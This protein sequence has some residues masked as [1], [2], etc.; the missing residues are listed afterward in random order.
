MDY[1]NWISVVAAVIALVS[2][3]TTI[4]YSR[5]QSRHAE[6]QTMLSLRIAVGQATSS[7]VDLLAQRSAI[8]DETPQSR[9]TASDRRRLSTLDLRIRVAIENHLNLYETACSNYLAGRIN[10][11]SFRKDFFHEVCGL[12]DSD[13]HWHKDFFFPES[14]SKHQSILTVYR[15]WKHPR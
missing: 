1:S 13:D 3:V 2:C 5:L 7:V 10:R 8:C 4:L 12:V 6:A 14:K 11:Q 15:K 9:L